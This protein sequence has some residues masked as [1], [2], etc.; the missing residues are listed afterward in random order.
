MTTAAPVP[1]GAAYANNNIYGNA[2]FAGMLEGIVEGRAGTPTNPA[3]ASVTAA[4]VTAARAFAVEF[5][6]L[7]SNDAQVTT[8]AAVTQLAITTN[9]I[10]ANEQWKAGLL[11]SLCRAYWKDRFTTDPTSADYANAAN[12]I[13]ASWLLGGVQLTTP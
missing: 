1:A 10:A 12:S 9:T 13:L 6:S 5:D 3:A 4:M 2:A 7:V 11:Q 8:G